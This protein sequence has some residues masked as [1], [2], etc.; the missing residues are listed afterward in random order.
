MSSD[1]P[2]AR[3]TGPGQP[4]LLVVIDEFSAS[5]DQFQAQHRTG[6]SPFTELVDRFV[7]A[8]IAEA[9]RLS[10]TRTKR[11]GAQA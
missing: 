4:R 5:A 2:P 9:P 3:L 1:R 7:A 11:P 6:L 10:L 8:G